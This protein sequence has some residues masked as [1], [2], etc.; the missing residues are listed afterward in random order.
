MARWG[1]VGTG[2]VVTVAAIACGEVLNSADDPS[3][4]PVRDSGT[5]VLDGGGTDDGPAAGCNDT[6]SQ[7]E[8]CGKCGHSCGGGQCVQSVCT[9]TVIAAGTITPLG[10]AVDDTHVYWTSSTSSGT[11]QRIAKTTRD[12]GVPETFEPSAGNAP[13]GIAVN[14]TTVFWTTS[15]SLSRKSK[16]AGSSPITMAPPIDSQGI[17]WMS[18]TESDV[19]YSAQ[20]STGNGVI[21]VSPEFAGA[22][23]LA[24]GEAI[25]F[26][27]ENA[28]AFYAGSSNSAINVSNGSM[29][30]KTA[31][32]YDGVAWIALGPDDVWWSTRAVSGT[33]RATPFR[34]RMRQVSAPEAR[35][36]AASSTT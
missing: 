36:R 3:L 32:T 24:D 14:A 28:I 21:R 1:F 27:V 34:T 29:D 23:R 15:A 9:P 25:A 8:H 2:M 17:W 30:A 20:S 12:N 5:N 6:T 33:S 11:I 4:P 18:A 22:E 10:I 19:V 31:T 35:I 7:S 16:T 13:K 26:A